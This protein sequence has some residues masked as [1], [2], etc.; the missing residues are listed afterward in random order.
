M[1]VKT[2]TGSDSSNYTLFG[3]KHLMSYRARQDSNLQPSDSKSVTL[4]S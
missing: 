4:S 3:L 2:L 1:V